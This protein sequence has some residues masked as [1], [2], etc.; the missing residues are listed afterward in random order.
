VP[1]H[2]CVDEFVVLHAAQPPQLVTSVVFVSQP[3]ACL[4]PLQ[5][6]LFAAHVPLQTP[7]PHVR[8]A[9]LFV[10]HTVLHDPQL[11]GSL[12]GVTSQPSV[13]LLLLQS[14]VPV[15]HVP[16]HVP[17]PHV[18]VA[19][20]LLE[21]DC[22]QPPQLFGSDVIPVSQPSVRRLLLQSR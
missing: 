1:L 19:M 11:F 9:M 14:A 15:M 10:E 2:D 21:Q 4:L 7:L 22:E 20:L 13:S 3:S 18:R 6:A 5:S 12:D 16:L 17:A 8:V